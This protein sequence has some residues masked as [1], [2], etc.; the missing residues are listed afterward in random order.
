MF[1]KC[2][3]TKSEPP[4]D[5]NHLEKVRNY[6]DGS[7]SICCYKKN[8][9]TLKKQ[10]NT[11]TSIIR[12]CPKTKPF[13]PCNNG[14]IAKEKK[15]IDGSHSICCYKDLKKNT[16]NIKPKTKN[17][18]K[19]NNSEN[20]N[21]YFN[22]DGI[23]L[24]GG[25]KNDSKCTFSKEIG[26]CTFSDKYMSERDKD[27]IMVL[28][29]KYDHNNAFDSDGDKGL[30][31]IFKSMKEF[32]FIYNKVGSI[33]EIK[34]IISNLP[35][36]SKIAHLVIMAH[37]NVNYIQLNKNFNIDFTNIKEFTDIIRP[38]LSPEC[39]VFLHSCLVGKG[40]PNS[41]TINFC[42]KLSK[43]LPGNAIFGSE[44][45]IQRGDLEVLLAENK[46]NKRYLNMFYF[47]DETKDYE[48]YT[49]FTQK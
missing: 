25:N 44:K 22:N 7:K 47:I 4:C 42:Q 20:N 38:K 2:P 6:K 15:Y 41:K 28:Q 13:P 12:D 19:K 18:T 30:F 8:K 23:C 21:C 5:K 40:G 39:S 27:V 49:F 10:N 46:Y 33:K 3:K 29:T 9:M 35:K 43:L 26:E 1:R 37:G 36:N 45:S 34:D 32:D 17:T 48:L 24:P 11:T 14:F 31:S 16:Q